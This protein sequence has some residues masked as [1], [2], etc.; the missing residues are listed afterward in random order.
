MTEPKKVPNLQ[1]SFSANDFVS[2]ARDSDDLRVNQCIYDIG[3]ACRS[4]L[5]NATVAQHVVDQ[6]TTTSHHQIDLLNFL[7]SEGYLD[8]FRYNLAIQT[9]NDPDEF[10]EEAY[11]N[12]NLLYD[13]VYRAKIYPYNLA[14]L[15]LDQSPW[16]VS[17]IQID[18]DIFENNEDDFLVW[19]HVGETFSMDALDEE[20]ANEATNPIFIVGNGQEFDE[21]DSIVSIDLQEMDGSDLRIPNGSFPKWRMI[22]AVA[23]F[24]FEESGNAEYRIYTV[25]FS[26]DHPDGAGTVF[27]RALPPSQIGVPLTFNYTLTCDPNTNLDVCN[28]GFFA[29]EFDWGAIPKSSVN[30]CRGV[31]VSLNH[32]RKYNND[33]YLRNP[34]NINQTGMNWTG[35]MPNHFSE[36]IQTDGRGA[37]LLRRLNQ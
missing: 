3:V 16:I 34:F 23:A 25:E 27:T 36:F 15:D 14:T 37:A 4:I 32:A 31:R 10:D 2:N 28:S 19:R 17:S 12:Q 11:I 9:G 29:H 5:I 13:T 8:E 7:D 6:A 22:T 26:E 35:L 24:D 33:W 1:G 30:C 20:D 18:E 21:G